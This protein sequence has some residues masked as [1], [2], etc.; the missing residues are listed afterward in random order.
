[1]NDDLV[2]LQH[3]KVARKLMCS[4]KAVSSEPEDL[5]ALSAAEGEDG[6]PNGQGGAIGRSEED[7]EVPKEEDTED[8]EQDSLEGE[9]EE[10]EG[11]Y[12]FV[13]VVADVVQRK[14]SE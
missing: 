8:V 10:H 3:L 4:L 2:Y 11:D 13:T 12:E 9:T 6:T 7:S 1:M 5:K 14:K